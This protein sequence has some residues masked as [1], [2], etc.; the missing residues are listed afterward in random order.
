MFVTQHSK[1][2]PAAEAESGAT[3]FDSRASTDTRLAA[4]LGSQLTCALSMHH[5]S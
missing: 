4:R 1:S 5:V 2:Q 3:S